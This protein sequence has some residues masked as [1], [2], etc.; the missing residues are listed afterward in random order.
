VLVLPLAVVVSAL[1]VPLS[2]I[3]AFSL[4]LMV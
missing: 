1:V 2:A 3:A 4:V